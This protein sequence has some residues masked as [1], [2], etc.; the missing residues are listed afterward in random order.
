MTAQRRARPESPGGP[1]KPRP[2]IRRH[3]APKPE[4]PA[5]EPGTMPENPA[6]IDREHE[7]AGIAPGTDR[8]K[9]R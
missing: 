6:S 4:M 9:E 3:P 1:A 8:T 7:P 5:P 2:E